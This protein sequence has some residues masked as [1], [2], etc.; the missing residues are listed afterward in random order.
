M[1]CLHCR[2]FQ[3]HTLELLNHKGLKTVLSEVN[4]KPPI[5]FSGLWDQAPSALVLSHTMANI[6]LSCRKEQNCPGTFCSLKKNPSKQ[7]K[8]YFLAIQ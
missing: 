8:K 5:A 4:G 7:K 2:R 3:V 6:S 1:I